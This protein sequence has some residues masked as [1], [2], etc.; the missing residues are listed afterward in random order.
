LLS[1]TAVALLAALCAGL[2]A[3]QY[4]WTGQ[5][6]DAERQRLQ[7]TLASRLRALAREF[8]TQ[9]SGACSTILPGALPSGDGP[10]AAMFRRSTVVAAGEDSPLADN[11]LVLKCPPGP[12]DGERLLLEFDPA[13]LRERLFPDYVNRYLTDSGRLDY[14]VEVVAAARPSPVIYETL[15]DAANPIG[16]SADAEVRLLGPRMGPVPFGGSPFRRPPPDG[17]PDEP[18]FGAPGEPGPPPEPGMWVLRVRHRAGSLEALVQQVRLRNLTVSSGL[19][20]LI[21]VTALM[22]VRFSRQAQRLAELE[23]N[24]VAGVSH[25]LRTPLT[26]IHTAA[27]NL[28]GKLAQQPEQVEKYGALIQRESSKLGAL[29]EQVLRFASA[30]RVARKPEPIDVAALIERS[31]PPGG[32]NADLTIEK[33]L[34]ADLP[35]V[36]AD[37]EA[38]SLALRNL[39]DNAIKHGTADGRWIGIAAT[40]VPSREGLA[41]EISVSDHGP[42]IPADELE[43]VFEP[44]F[45]GQYAIAEQIHGTGLGLSLVKRMVE[46]QGGSVRVESEPGRGAVFFIRLPAAVAS[47]T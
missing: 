2:G 4:R 37:A 5:I 3:L 16:A 41:V 9:I 43:H 32:E 25:E 12:P 38:A 33:Q 11:P 46:T 44:F 1:W 39:V 26:V 23:M 22:L 10:Y 34:P 14:D 40:P 45:R 27:F 6:S 8:D 20:L 29:V 31:L 17:R 35:A 7:A 36:L 30:G 28:R 21:L 24:F 47:P 18:G 13:Y 42:G 15:M 19:L